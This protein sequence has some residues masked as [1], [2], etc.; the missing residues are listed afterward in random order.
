M[1]PLLSWILTFSI[2]KISDALIDRMYNP[3]F[4]KQLEKVFLDWA[5][6]L[7]KDKQTWPDVFFMTDKKVEIG[8]SHQKLNEAF[9]IIGSIPTIEIWN[10]ALI[11]R[12]QE[13]KSVLGDSANG[14]FKQ[15]AESV[16]AV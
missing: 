2:G 5:K 16:L 15:D 6:S 11:E 12:W 10:D 3:A 13:R 7:P 1:Y 9:C 8:K 4:N 14:F